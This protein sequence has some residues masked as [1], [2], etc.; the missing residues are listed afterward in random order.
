MTTETK[1]LG[2]ILIITALLLFG[3]IFLFSRS[4]SSSQSVK[5]TAVL[6]IDYTKGQKIGSSSAKVNL[7]EFSDFECPACK[8]V[9]P[10]IKQVLERFPNDLQFIYRHF[11]LPQH[12][13]ARAA[14]VLAEQAGEEGKFWQMHDLI[15][16][17]QEKWSNLNDPME[18]FLD[19]AEQLNLDRDQVKNALSE[20]IFDDFINQDIVD[21][22]NL[23]V[24]STPTFF[25]NGKKLSLVSFD[26]L[27]AA[28]ESELS[29]K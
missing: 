6:Q 25:L 22:Q 5:G 1:V 26:D 9:E 20:K 4:Q 21:G 3:G 10:I 29:S 7:V 11:P 19:L 14:A 12:K 18:F 23:G 17:T 13:N 27:I 28:V 15:F 2:I 24:N 8:S 16:E